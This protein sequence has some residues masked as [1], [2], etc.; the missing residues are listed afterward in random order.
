MLIT[1]LSNSRHTVYSLN[2]NN[3]LLLVQSASEK[4][5]SNSR[6]IV[7]TIFGA[8]I[9][10]RYDRLIPMYCPKCGNKTDENMRICVKCGT[11][12]YASETDIQ[13]LTHS[14]VQEQG[15]TE[16]VVSVVLGIIAL[17]SLCSSTVFFVGS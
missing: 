6:E 10:L 9:A 7:L 14:Y 11:K 8:S 1:T 4:S 16:A 12:L 5:K 17:L 2:S 15:K 3:L 13:N